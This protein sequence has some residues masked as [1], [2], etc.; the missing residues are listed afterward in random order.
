MR[1]KFS[2]NCVIREHIKQTSPVMSLEYLLKNAMTFKATDPRDQVYA[3]LGLAQ[4]EDQ[5]AI[6]VDYSKSIKQ[7][8]IEAAQYAISSFGINMICFSTNSPRYNLPSWVSDWSWS[9]ARWPLWT[10]ATYNVSGV[11]QTS[12]QFSDN[13]AIISVSGIMIDLLTVVDSSDSIGPGSDVHLNDLLDSIEST[14]NKAITDDHSQKL[15]LLHPANSDMLWRTLVA[16]QSMLLEPSARTKT[17]APNIYARQYEVMR[18]RS[19]VPEDF[20]SELDAAS[21]KVKFTHQ[22]S[23]S[24]QHTLEEQRFLLLVKAVS[25][26]ALLV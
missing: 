8:Y 3:L 15:N 12:V 25:G 1:S 10:E 6:Q 24:M 20:M 14:L 26:L 19:E 22:V 4:K 13:P 7:V 2:A 17:P 21:K 11:I 23:L 9:T 16:N 5:A 18:G